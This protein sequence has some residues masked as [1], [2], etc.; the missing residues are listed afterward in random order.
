MLIAMVKCVRPQRCVQMMHEVDVLRIV[1]RRAL[2]DQA[3]FDTPEGPLPG[4]APVAMQQGV[5]AAANILRDVAGK[6]R[7]PFRYL[8]K[9]TM[10]VIGRANAVVELPVGRLTG[11]L[12]WLTWIFVHIMYLVGHR[13]RIIVLLNWAWSYF[14][15]KRGARLIT[16]RVWKET[17]AAAL[18]PAVANVEESAAVRVP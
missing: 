16:Q 10:A 11:L 4:L 14:T 6:P 12:G 9:G 7:K 1:E 5:A 18:P 8:N 17:D 15:F 13:N 3:R 2:G